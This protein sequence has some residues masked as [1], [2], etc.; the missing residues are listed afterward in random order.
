[1]TEECAL[2]RLNE[3]SGGRRQENIRA[4]NQLA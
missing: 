1:M 2:R 3:R 4:R